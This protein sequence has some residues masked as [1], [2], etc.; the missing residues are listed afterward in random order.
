M[1]RNNLVGQNAFINTS[2][3]T[4][5]PEHFDPLTARFTLESCRANGKRLCACIGKGATKSGSVSLANPFVAYGDCAG[6][7][8]WRLLRRG[9]D[10]HLRYH[11]VGEGEDDAAV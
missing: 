7:P 11:P 4:T 5:Q 1:I 6:P 8:W 3:L 9:T 10:E 2:S